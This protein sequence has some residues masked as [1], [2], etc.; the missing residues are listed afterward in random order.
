ML[1]NGVLVNEVN[2]GTVVNQCMHIIDMG[3]GGNVGVPDQ[4]G[5]KGLYV[6]GRP[7]IFVVCAT[8]TNSGGGED[9]GNRAS[10]QGVEEIFIAF[11][12]A[13]A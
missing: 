10:D 12:I 3:R 13:D 2:W 1:D 7:N 8:S 5:V 11:V 9:S 4:V 6:L